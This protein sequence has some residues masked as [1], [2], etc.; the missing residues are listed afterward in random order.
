[1]TTSTAPERPTEVGGAEPGSEGAAQAAGGWM[2]LNGEIDGP[3]RDRSWRVLPAAYTI[4]R[5]PR[6]DP[7]HIGGADESGP[8][9]SGN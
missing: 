7:D 9:T 4:V 3:V 5:A 1:M 6:E 8:G 2:S